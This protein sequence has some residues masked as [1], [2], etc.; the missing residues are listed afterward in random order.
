MT[1]VTDRVIRD[2]DA[3]T[4]EP[5]EWLDEFA[6]KEVRDYA[7]TKFFANE[8]SPIF[9]EID[10][11]RVLQSDPEFRASAEKEIMLR[12]N[13]RAHGAWDS[14][15]RSEAL[16]HMG[17]SSQLIFPTMPNTLLEVMEHEAPPK[18]TYDTASAANR[19]QIAFCSNDPRLLPVAYIPLQDLVLAAPCATEAIEAGASALLIPNPVSYT[20]LRAHET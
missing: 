18:L 8:G 11:C 14:L 10:Q 2:A 17:F 12:K 19:A 16:N 3:H 13:Y 1:D 15:D 5:P 6:S 20:H 4:M 9:N 7:R